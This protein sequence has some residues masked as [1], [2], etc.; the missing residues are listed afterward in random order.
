M[1]SSQPP[2]AQRTANASLYQRTEVNDARDRTE[3]L[4]LTADIVSSQMSN[5]PVAVSDLPR[6]IGNVYLALSGLGTQATPKQV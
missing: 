3:L 6:L 1:A 2:D 5:N 4:S